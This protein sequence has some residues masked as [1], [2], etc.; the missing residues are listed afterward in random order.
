M[1]QTA[2]IIMVVLLSLS[3]VT[4]SVLSI[5]S[6]HYDIEISKDL[7]E[8]DTQ[9]ESEKEIEEKDAFFE[10]FITLQI[11]ALE[12]T[13]RVNYSYSLGESYFTAEIHLP[14]PK[15]TV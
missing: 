2:H 7:G 4:P 1:K 3:I 14:P 8:D 9:K 13:E 12:H 11:V 10:S 5:Y 6:D 15:Y